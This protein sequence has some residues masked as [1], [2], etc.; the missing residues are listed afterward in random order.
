MKLKKKDKVIIASVI[1]I[2]GIAV[3]ISYF[4]FLYEPTFP[5]ESDKLIG[6]WY[7]P[8][9]GF[10]NWTIYFYSN[11]SGKEIQGSCLPEPYNDSFLW[12][13]SNETLCLEYLNKNTS[14]CMGGRFI[15]DYNHL[16]LIVSELEPLELEIKFKFEKID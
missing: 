14:V 13:I 4:I 3:G 5:L 10:G 9:L 6:T 12:E 11:G 7:N 2:T 8:G 15:D 16:E 1:M